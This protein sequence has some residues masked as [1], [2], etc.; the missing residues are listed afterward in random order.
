MSGPH[1]NLPGQ[2]RARG[3]N[4]LTTDEA[5]VSSTTETP[6]GE[7]LGVDVS[8]GVVTINQPSLPDEGALFGVYD[9]SGNARS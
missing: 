3:L 6:V 1:R 9:Y 7:F 5:I 4:T 8:G 2:L